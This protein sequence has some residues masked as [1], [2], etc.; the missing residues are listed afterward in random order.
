MIAACF[1]VLHRRWLA[2]WVNSNYV[3][4]RTAWEYASIIPTA[5]GQRPLNTAL[6][7][8][9]WFMADRSKR[10]I[11]WQGHTM[12]QMSVVLALL[13]GLSLGGLGLCFSLLQQPS[14]KPSGGYAAIFLL[15][16][17]AL[18]V[19]VLSSITATVTRLLDFRLTAQK[20]RSGEQDEPLTD[21]GTDAT[22][23]GKA[24][25]RLFWCTA[26]LLCIAV[27]LLSIV[28]AKVYL[29]GMFNAA[30]L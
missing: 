8:R 11:R 20:V 17:L 13:S 1:M 29:G 22:G 27:V 16:L 28:V 19:A 21:F 6:E 14:F 3:S 9:G 2:E 12:A 5:A 24:T 7:P 26:V 18:L 25:W 4:T 15:T 10:F 23:Y 30:G